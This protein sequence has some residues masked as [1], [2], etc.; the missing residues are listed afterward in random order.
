[1]TLHWKTSED[2]LFTGLS[3]NRVYQV[4]KHADRR[5]QLRVR[6]RARPV[7][8]PLDDLWQTLGRYNNPAVAMIHADCHEEKA[9]EAA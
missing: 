3:C 6:D 9:R 7:G 5:W 4:I 8:V 1:M 2:N